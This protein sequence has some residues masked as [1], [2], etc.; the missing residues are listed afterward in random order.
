M[1]TGCAPVLIHW[2]HGRLEDRGGGLG[3][4]LISTTLRP[5]GPVALIEYIGCAIMQPLG[6]LRGSNAVSKSA[7]LHQR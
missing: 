7:F 5:K 6:R 1:S 3:T 2:Y 4:G